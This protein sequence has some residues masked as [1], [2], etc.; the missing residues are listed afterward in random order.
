[1]RVEPE[2]GGCAG[3]PRACHSQLYP[4]ADGL[5]FRLAGAEDIAAVDALFEQC[6]AAGIHDD[7]ARPRAQPKEPR[8]S[9]IPKRSP[10]RTVLPKSL[11]D[12]KEQESSH[13]QRRS[14]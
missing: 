8:I 13:D 3:C 5:V 4:I 1:M 10:A 14:A 9:A 7:L 6:P 2:H 12:W 11:I